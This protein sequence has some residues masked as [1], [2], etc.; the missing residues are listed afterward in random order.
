MTKDAW[1]D[2]LKDT[3]LI[4]NIEREVKSNF[5]GKPFAYDKERNIIAFKNGYVYDFR[6]GSITYGSPSMKCMRHLPLDYKEWDDAM[7]KEYEVLIQEIIKVLGSNRTRLF[8]WLCHGER[9]DK[10]LLFVID[11][12]GS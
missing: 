3:A 4:G 9:S 10:V 12:D 5:F 1:P 11:V 8:D 2:R 7:L 6:T